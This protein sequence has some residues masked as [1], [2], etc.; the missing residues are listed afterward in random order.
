MLAGKQL[1]KDGDKEM[2]DSRDSA[3]AVGSVFAQQGPSILLELPLAP[4]RESPMML[5]RVSNYLD[6]CGLVEPDATDREVTWNR[7]A[8]IKRV[9]R[10]QQEQQNVVRQKLLKAVRRILGVCGRGGELGHG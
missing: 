6:S 8:Y 1:L 10:L 7:E 3:V 2:R 9:V 4:P 5:A